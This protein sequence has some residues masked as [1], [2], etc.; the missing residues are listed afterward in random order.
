MYTRKQYFIKKGLQT[1]FIW[2]VLLIIF[3][4]F[5]I[6]SC[7]FF[8]F[9]TYLQSE[10]DST[11]LANLKDVYDISVAKLYDKLILLVV[12]NIFII[13]IISLF[14]SH[15]IAGP[16]FKLELTLKQI[17]EGRVKQRL[18]F[19]K[20]DKLDDLANQFNDA[21]AVVCRPALTLHESMA[22]L[23]TELAG[24]VA[25]RTLL[26]ELKQSIES[27]H[28]EDGLSAEDSEAGLGEVPQDAADGNPPQTTQG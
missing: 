23:E 16:V 21:L 28:F 1:R 12:V 22:R 7:N 15:Q 2:T 6:V 25:S 20:T 13:V 8:F 3:L 11:Q 19:R 27:F 18:F 14:F 4:V 24:S 26:D 10:L 5:V 9:A 17:R